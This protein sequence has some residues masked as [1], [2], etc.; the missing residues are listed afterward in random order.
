M[1]L[2]KRNMMQSENFQNFNLGERFS[3]KLPQTEFPDNNQNVFTTFE[4]VRIDENCQRTAYRKSG[5]G[6]ER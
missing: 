5:S 3:R 4:R 6:I 1:Q 2:S